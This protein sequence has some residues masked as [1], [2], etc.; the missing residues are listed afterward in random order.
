VAITANDG[1]VTLQGPAADAQQ[2][3]LARLITVN[4]CGVKQVNSDLQIPSRP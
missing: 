2:A 3:E 4:T 1:I